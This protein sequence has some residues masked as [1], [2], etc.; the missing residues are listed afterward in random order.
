[1]T[2]AKPARVSD[3]GAQIVAW[4]RDDAIKQRSDLRGLHARK[5]L[6]TA[7]TIEWEAQIELK[8]A[9]A[10]AI[11][12]GDHIPCPARSVGEIA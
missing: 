10:D 8:A 11:E 1:M 9:L 5:M 7:Q 4:L 12:R 6:T 3:E 2:S